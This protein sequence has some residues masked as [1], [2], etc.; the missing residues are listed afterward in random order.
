[1][2][3]KR[4][5]FKAISDVFRAVNNDESECFEIFGKMEDGY[6]EVGEKQLAILEEL[7]KCKITKRV[8]FGDGEVFI[9]RTRPSFSEYGVKYD[10][11]T[12]HYVQFRNEDDWREVQSVIEAAI[13][14]EMPRDISK[15]SVALDGV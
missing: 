2:K 10:D 12:E 3:N 6:V 4:E 13:T 8:E 7:E 5:K 11:H 9:I 15:S 1:M 14:A